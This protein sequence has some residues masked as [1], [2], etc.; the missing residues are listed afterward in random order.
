MVKL[1]C[2]IVG[3]ESSAFSVEIDENESV[4]A[5][6]VA[7]LARKMYEFPADE[8]KLFPA[9]N[10]NAWLSS[11]TEDVKKLKKGEK[12]PLIKA[13]TKEN[14]ELQAEFPLKDMLNGIDPPHC[15]VRSTCWWWFQ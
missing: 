12:T 10:D 13:L 14:Q 9:K 7:I 11:L 3:V 4:D 2:A 1:S 5:L 6:K 15:I 8:L